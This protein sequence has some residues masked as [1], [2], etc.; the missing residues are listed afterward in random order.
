MG[1]EEPVAASCGRAKTATLILLQR[2]A[3]REQHEIV[4]ELVSGDPCWARE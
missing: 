4:V 3:G 1:P 2:P